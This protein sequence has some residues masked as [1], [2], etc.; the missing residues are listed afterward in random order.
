[1]IDAILDKYTDK[2]AS[3]RRQDSSFVE[4]FYSKDATAV[5]PGRA[6]LLGRESLREFY[7]ALVSRPLDASYQSYRFVATSPTT[8]HDFADFSITPEG[9]EC[10]PM[11]FLFTWLRED[12]EWFCNGYMYIRGERFM[13]AATA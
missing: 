12:G 3:L 5:A 2:V 6:P 1:M 9:G 4:R 7:N 8:A 10:I 13:A 11:K